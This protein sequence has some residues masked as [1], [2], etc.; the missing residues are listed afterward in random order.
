MEKSQKESRSRDV[1]C[2]II[3]CLF[4]ISLLLF[5]AINIQNYQKPLNDFVQN[6]LLL[7]NFQKQVKDKLMTESLK[8]HYH[9]IDGSGLYARI[10]GRRVFNAVVRLNNG[11]LTGK[12]S[13]IP[14]MGKKAEALK[15]LNET[16]GSYGGKF[17]Y[18]QFP[19]KMDLEQKMAPAGLT[20]QLTINNE[21]EGFVSLLQNEGIDTIDTIPN[22]AKTQELVEETFYRT[23]HHWKP[24][25]AFKAFCMIMEHLQ[26]LYPEQETFGSF[27]ADPENWTV[28][29]MEHQFLGSRGKRTGV[30]YGGVDPLQWMTPKFDT[31]FSSYVQNHDTFKKGNFEDACL[32]KSYLD[33]DPQLHKKNHYCIT[34]GGDYPLV[35]YR[36]QYAPSELSVLIL[37]DSFTLPLQTYLATAFQKVD[38]IDPRYFKECSIL[39]Y[40]DRTK[41]DI[42]ILEINPGG[43]ASETFFTF[44]DILP[45]DP[46]L[47]EVL[48]SSEIE[49][50]FASESQYNFITVHDEF[51]NNRVYSL[52]LSGI[53]IT[54]VSEEV[55]QGVSIVLYDKAQK[56]AITRSAFDIEYCNFSG[57]CYWT[58]QTPEENSE[59][60]ALLIYA[61][62]Q[63]NTRNN[64]IAIKDLQLIRG[65]MT[66][67]KTN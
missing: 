46:E 30:Y 47:S 23:D 29:E 49:T 63:G 27:Y 16:V 2:I 38:I 18:V 9:F 52:S 45:D 15:T 3:G 26:D 58:F 25:A 44:G 34:V 4:S 40:I 11:M 33:P 12:S 13:M 20:S 1:S 61:G 57:D 7:P 14:D 22:F 36:N 19:Y 64:G 39:E 65:K 41:P 48:V 55:P 59:D 50:I 28:H 42:V 21:T 62:M 24:S 32:I 31:Y 67:K 35:Q 17:V 53:E 51:E 8:G 60:L 66:G 54:D 43:S 37:K 10:S 5:S 6:A 56:K